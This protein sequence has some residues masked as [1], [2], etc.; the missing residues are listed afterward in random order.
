MQI[1]TLTQSFSVCKISDISQVDYSA[2]FC[3]VGKT[4][5]EI[6]L[7]C[8]T[9]LVPAGALQRED[10]W[11]AFRIAALLDFSLIGVLSKIST[12]LAD[13]QIGIFVVSTFNTDYVLIK[14]EQFGKA[15]SCLQNAGYEI[16]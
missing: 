13:S 11:K 4:D 8:E 6:S 12:L 5:E 15:L 2:P 1:K 16:V 14:E 7:V 10:G 9:A 3:F